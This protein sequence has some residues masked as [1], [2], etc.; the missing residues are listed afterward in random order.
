MGVEPPRLV[1]DCAENKSYIALSYCWGEPQ[2]I[3]LTARSLDIFKEGIDMQI[4]P[5]TIQ[6]AI[7]VTRGLRQ[8]YLWVD[9]LCI[10]QDD[11]DAKARD[12][13]E[14]HDIYKNAFLTICASSASRCSEGFLMNFTER[15]PIAIRVPFHLPG[16]VAG[17]II[18]RE[19]LTINRS[20]QAPLDLRAWTYQEGTLSP[21]NLIFDWIVYL[22]CCKRPMTPAELRPSSSFPEY[23]EF[24]GARIWKTRMEPDLASIEDN[25]RLSTIKAHDRW[26]D[27]I[28]EY[29]R[30]TM[31]NER[32]K[33]PAFAGLAIQFTRQTGFHYLAGL[34][35]ETLLVD[36]LWQVSAF[37]RGPRLQTRRAPS[38]S[39][40]SID[41]TIDTSSLRQ[42]LS[43]DSVDSRYS[44]LPFVL[45]ILTVLCTPV[46][47][48]AIYGENLQGIIRVKGYL[49]PVHYVG[50]ASTSEEFEARLLELD[51]RSP[52]VHSIDLRVKLDTTDDLASAELHPEYWALP[53]LTSLYNA[54]LILSQYSPGLFRRIGHFDEHWKQGPRSITSN[55]KSWQAMWKPAILD[56]M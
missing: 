24:T 47:E 15:F 3:T 29:T 45:E 2:L 11:E 21:R 42:Y 38:W 7:T 43:A 41:G 48:D 8:Q 14:M 33:L 39:W 53:V 12:I 25:L 46:F 30:R 20:K 27:D 31:T 23:E 51:G 28:D 9:A 5:R 37:D 52:T 17:T 36:L 50:K 22:Q 13:S 19:Q 55:S 10:F 26:K 44:E 40:A 1:I 18:L 49:V 54:G 56:I 32:D 35:R 4:L 16:R 6:D 34:W